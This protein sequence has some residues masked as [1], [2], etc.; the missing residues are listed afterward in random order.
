[1]S[2][3]YERIAEAIDYLSRHA[4]EQPLLEEVAESIGVSPFHFQRTFRRWAGIT[5]KQFLQFLTLEHAKEL[6]DQRHSVLDVAFETGLSSPARVHDHFVTLEAVTPGEYKGHGAGLL[7][8]YGTATTLFGEAFIAQT[9]RGIC[10]FAFLDTDLQQQI[11]D[12][13]AQWESAELIR[14]DAAAQTVADRLFD[15]AAAGTNEPLRVV[16]RG[17]NFQVR[18]W[19]ALLEIPFG[20]VRSYEQL[21]TAMGDPKAARAVGNA[22]ARNTVGYLIPCHRVILSTGAVGNYRWAPHRKRA[23]LAWEAAR[24]TPA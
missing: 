4:A 2:T 19:R 22:L 5:P 8:R 10:A 21:A 23:L 16:A 6:L 12:L 15:P 24:N 7:I 20:E 14:D 3:D 17:T 9:E 13:H 11:D 18:V 1:M